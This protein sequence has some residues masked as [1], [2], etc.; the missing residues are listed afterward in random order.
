[1]ELVL[2]TPATKETAEK[3]HHHKHINMMVSEYPR[4]QGWRTGETPG[5]WG[6]LLG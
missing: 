3:N 4:G 1:M 2:V 6:V 5:K